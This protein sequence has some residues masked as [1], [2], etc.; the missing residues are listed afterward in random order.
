MMLW[1]GYSK[2]SSH[3]SYEALI[4]DNFAVLAAILGYVVIVL[5][6]MQVGLATDR[7]QS[8]QAFQ[9]ASYGFTVLAM[10]VPL[11]ASVVIFIAVTVIF[12]YNWG[13]TGVYEKKTWE[14][15]GVEPE[16]LHRGDGSSL[17]TSVSSRAKVNGDR[18]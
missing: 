15:M 17:N 13:V 18:P 10:I 8:N 7:L 4:W 9:N 1:R 16:W 6:A 5:T 12:L 2:V 3:D 11:I 14:R